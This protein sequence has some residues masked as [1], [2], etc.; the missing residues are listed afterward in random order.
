[1]FRRALNARRW[2]MGGVGRDVF[3]IYSYNPNKSSL[4]VH[5]RFSILLNARAPNLRSF[6]ANLAPLPPFYQQG[7]AGGRGR[8]TRESTRCNTRGTWSAAGGIQW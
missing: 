1:M 3:T 4:Y 6:C 5:Y 8:Y 2:V 7:R